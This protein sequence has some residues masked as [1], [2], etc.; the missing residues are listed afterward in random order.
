LIIDITAD[1]FPEVDDPAI[2]TTDR[3]WHDRFEIKD[4]HSADL[5]YYDGQT[6]AELSLVYYKVVDYLENK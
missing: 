3:A 6:K 4:I 5:D 1:Q 2:V